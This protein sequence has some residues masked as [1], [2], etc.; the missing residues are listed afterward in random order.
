MDQG[1]RIVFIQ[2]VSHNLASRVDVPRCVRP[3]SL[4]RYSSSALH[5]GLDL[6][7]AMTTHLFFPRVLNALL[8][9]FLTFP[10][11]TIAAINGH[12]FAGGFTL[13]LAHD[14]RVM[15]QAE[16]K[17]QIWCALNEID[18]GANVSIVWCNGLR[19][20]FSVAAA[21]VLSYLAYP[22]Q[23][24]AGM[25]AIA[26]AKITDA[27][28]LRTIALEGQRIGAQQALQFRIVD[29]VGKDGQEVVNKAVQIGIKDAP[30]AK[31][32]AWGLIKAGMYKEAIVELAIDRGNDGLGMHAR[33]GGGAKL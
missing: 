17:A 18:F 10:I 27:T 13:A 5:I 15:K 28:A 24:P 21:R 26:K 14:F 25:M 20:I 31:Q 12:C 1:T 30:K 6:P 4:C 3:D 19:T 11:P 23:L 32:Q 16:G 22:P 9:R 7:K 33:I 2:M 29:E 8:G